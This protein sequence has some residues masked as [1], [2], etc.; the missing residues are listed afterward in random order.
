MDQDLIVRS[1]QT[2]ALMP[3]MQFSVAP[4]RILDEE[5]LKAVRKAIEI[6]Q[7]Y[8][9]LILTLAQESAGNGEPIV[10]S[11]EYLFPHKGYHAIDDQFL[12]GDSILV[13]PFLGPGEGKRQVMIP[14][15]T[16]ERLE[17]EKHQGAKS[18]GYYC[19]TGCYSY[20]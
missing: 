5:H 13:T 7:Q 12:L 6:R 17:R 3:M 1:A 16:L 2:H 15:R 14:G 10:R 9:P 11:M 18:S 20:L 8:T 4:W 19:G